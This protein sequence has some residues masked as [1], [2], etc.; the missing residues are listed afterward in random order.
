VANTGS[1]AAGVRGDSTAGRGVYGTSSSGSGGYF[2]STTGNGITVV[3]GTGINSTGG[4][5]VYST[6]TASNGVGLWGVANTGS[7]AKGV[8][9]TSTSGSG[10]YGTSAAASGAGVH[11]RATANEGRGVYGFASGEPAAYGVLGESSTG[12]AG[13]FIGDVGVTGSC[14]AMG[15]GYTRIDH[16]LDPENRYLNQA[17]VQSPEMITVVSGNVT[18]DAA[19]EAVATL[20]TYFAAANTDFRY[21]LTVIGQFAQ[22]IVLQELANDSFIIKT[23]KPNVKVS[24]QVT[25]TRNDPYARSHPFDAEAAKP[26]YEKGTYLY[27]AEYGQPEEKGTTH[28]I[29]RDNK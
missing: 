17:L 24:W 22:A 10:V 5:G 16:P 13:Y 20:P 12:W 8:Y 4:N 2:T 7:S 28:G 9:G 15:V 14:C 21:Q 1:S 18:T 26:D 19:G 11:G 29:E 27:P 25:G 6:G 3:G 23:D